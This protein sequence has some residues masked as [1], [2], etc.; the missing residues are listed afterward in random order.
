MLGIFAIIIHLIYRLL[1]DTVSSFNRKYLK[2]LDALRALTYYFNFKDAPRL[3]YLTFNSYIKEGNNY[4]EKNKSIF[5]SI[6][7]GIIFALTV[8][9]HLLIDNNPIFSNNV[10]PLI[11][12]I[13]L[14]LFLIA[15]LVIA[16]LIY[17]SNKINQIEQSQKRT[18]E[19]KAEQIILFVEIAILVILDII[20]FKES[21]LQELFTLNLVALV[22]ITLLYQPTKMATKEKNTR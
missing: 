3:S 16:P 8:M 21:I 4:I 20:F 15:I 22:L 5:V 19:I 6:N 7:I 2:L 12:V 11:V 18:T 13:V 1:N 10:S 17:I 14:F 9:W